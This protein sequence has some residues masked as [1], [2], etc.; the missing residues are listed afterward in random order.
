MNL[1]NRPQGPLESEA[2]LQE[3]AKGYVQSAPQGTNN[4]SVT[5]HSTAIGLGS[6]VPLRQ[7]LSLKPSALILGFCFNLGL[8]L[9]SL[10]AV[11]PGKVKALLLT[12]TIAAGAIGACVA[13]ASDVR[14]KACV[15]AGLVVL[16]LGFSLVV[17]LPLF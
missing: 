14:T 10:I 13:M 1:T 5:E 17:F 9:P 7:G 16:T 15:I 6:G 12:L 2:P 3:T 4:I 8:V 11:A